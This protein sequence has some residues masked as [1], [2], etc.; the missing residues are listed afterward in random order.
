[1]TLAITPGMTTHDPLPTAA[2][3]DM[4]AIT[5]AFRRRMGHDSGL[6]A[7]LKFDCGQDGVVVLD[8]RSVPN[9]VFNDDIDTDCTI[10]ISRDNLVALMTRKLDPALG[11]MTGKLKVSGQ[12]G[13]A[14]KL[15]RVM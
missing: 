12:M 1:M 4:T 10:E 2:F 3:M 15:Q 6:D 9:R 11:F 13:V 8:G 14:L 5:E 7:T